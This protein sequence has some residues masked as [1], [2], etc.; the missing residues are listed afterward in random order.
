M[1][2]LEK[3]RLTGDMIATFEYLNGCHVGNGADLFST[4]LEGRIQSN[5]RFPVNV[6][7]KFL[8]EREIWRWNGQHWKL[9]DSPSWEGF[10]PRLYGQMSRML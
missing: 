10:K 9:A 7:R 3:R 5:R 6:R 1:F 8:I 2:G 4:A